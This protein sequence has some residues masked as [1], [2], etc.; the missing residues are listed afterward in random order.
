MRPVI[1]YSKTMTRFQKVILRCAFIL[2]LAF[3]TYAQAFFHYL[4]TAK[5]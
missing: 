3:S 5:G 1:K 2:S 4:L